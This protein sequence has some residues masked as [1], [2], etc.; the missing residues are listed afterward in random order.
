MNTHKLLQNIT[1]YFSAVL[2][3]ALASLICETVRLVLAPTNMVMVYLLAVVFAAS[4]LG[5]KPAILTAALSVLAFDVLFV[6]PRF[7]LRVSD[8]EYVVTFFGLFVVG[9]VISTLVSRIK[10]KIEEAKNQEARTSSLFFLTRDLSS[11]VDIKSIIAALNRAITRNFDSKLLVII[12]N[13]GVLATVTCDNG[14]CPGSGMDEIINWVVTSGRRAGTGTTTFSNSSYLFIPIRSSEN[15]DGVM[16]LESH[17]VFTA[18]DQQ[19]IEAFSGQVA[20]AIERVQFYQQAEEARIMREKSQLEQALLNSISHDLRTPLVTISGVLDSMAN[21]D[22]EYDTQQ[23]KAMILAASE[24]AFRL[25]RFVS[26]LL[27]MTRLEAG[28]LTPRFELCE[29]EEI[30]GCAVGAVKTRLGTNTIAISVDSDLPPVPADLALL[31]QALVNLLDNALKFSPP[32]KE[33]LLTAKLR[34]GQIVIEVTD[35]GPGIP[36]GEESRIFDKFHRIKVP[37]TTGGTGLGLSIAKGIIEAHKGEISASN[38]P[39]GGL[40][41]QVS[42]PADVTHVNGEYYEC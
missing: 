37:E 34:D 38:R 3:V 13:N 18:D 35:H 32:S 27:D 17:T 26:S 24:E 22:Q 7:S 25:N 40:C 33:I 21:E 36:R 23:K 30:I 6:P 15:V 41:V 19:L 8:S 20:L 16:V 9:A 14:L 11:A 28:A 29:V 2:L 5:F 12:N 39:Q 42:L 4:K 10:E 1:R 31:T